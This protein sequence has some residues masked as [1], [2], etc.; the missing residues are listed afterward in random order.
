VYCGSGVSA[1][2]DLMALEAAGIHG[3]KL[4]AG[5][6]SDWVSYDDAPVAVGAEP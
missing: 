1:A 2:H 3:A 5:S 4:Y 6:W